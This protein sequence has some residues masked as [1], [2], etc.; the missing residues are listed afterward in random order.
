M[1][2]SSLACRELLGELDHCRIVT[3]CDVWRLRQDD[4]IQL[5]I[6]ARRLPHTL[7]ISSASALDKATRDS[8][9]QHGDSS[10]AASARHLP[11][12]GEEGHTA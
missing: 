3:K 8:W 12:K 1:S 10:S 2:G 5:A 7:A 6:Q 4:L 9:D 11:R